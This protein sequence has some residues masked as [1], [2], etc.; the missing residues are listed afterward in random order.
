M[1]EDKREEEIE[2]HKTYNTL[3]KFLINNIGFTF[4]TLVLVTG[5]GS[6]PWTCSSSLQ[7]WGRPWLPNSSSLK[8]SANKPWLWS[9]GCP[10]IARSPVRTPYLITLNPQGNYFSG[11]WYVDAY[12]PS[13]PQPLFNF[14]QH[15]FHN[16]DNISN[17]NFT[18]TWNVLPS[19]ILSHQTDCSEILIN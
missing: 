3:T 17:K 19:G 9:S 5:L 14:S 7:V 6:L 10:R 1:Y 15:E 4:K 2:E 11:L 16:V 18:C 12:P 8:S 13:G